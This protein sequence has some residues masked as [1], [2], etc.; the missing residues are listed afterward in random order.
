MPAGVAGARTERDEDE[1]ADEP[2]PE[3]RGSRRPRQASLS[4][5]AVVRPAASSVAVL[6]DR[7]RRC[8][9]AIG[10]SCS[11]LELDVR[12]E[13]DAKRLFGERLRL[14]FG[15]EAL[16]LHLVSAARVGLQLGVHESSRGGGRDE[17]LG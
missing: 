17:G 2:S 5:A 12:S 7:E 1:E 3:Q 15:R 16:L 14:V 8:V 6:D 13:P 9:S 11:A 4:V 10:E